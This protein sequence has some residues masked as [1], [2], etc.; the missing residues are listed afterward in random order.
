M[1]CLILFLFF[2]NQENTKI[3]KK[4]YVVGLTGG[5]A[6]GKSSVSE[7]LRNLGASVINCDLLA[8]ELYKKGEPLLQKLVDHFGE[9]ILD[10]DGEVNRK[11]LGSIVFNNEVIIIFVLK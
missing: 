10:S 6:S 9:K 8:H 7:R 4:P 3:P 2:N 11:A 1:L 5:I